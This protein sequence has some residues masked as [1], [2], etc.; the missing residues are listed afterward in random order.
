VAGLPNGLFELPRFE[1]PGALWESVD[2]H[3]PQK[4]IST[5]ADWGQRLHLNVA[6]I[7]RP[8]NRFDGPGDFQLM[9]REQI[10]AIHGFNEDMVLGWHVD[11]NLCRRLYLLNGNTESLLDHVFAYHCDHTRQV[12]AMHDSAQRTENDSK[13]FIYDVNSPYLLNQAET[14]GL[15]HEDIEET[16]LTS[17]T[18][19]TYGQA[20]EKLLPG[21]AEPVAWDSYLDES[22]DQSQIYDNSHV[23]P[24]LADY[25]I[26]I[27]RSSTIGYFGGNVELLDLL[28]KFLSKIGH[29][30][31]V[32]VDSDLMACAFPDRSP[33][34][35]ENFRLEVAERL[36]AQSD[37]YVF[38]IAL[39]HLQ[40]PSNAKDLASLITCQQA[41][42]FKEKLANFF[43][44]TVAY[45]RNRLLSKTNLERQFL[46]IGAHATWFERI[47]LK[48]M[49]TTV[50]PYSSHVRQGFASKTPQS[51]VS[52]WSFA[53]RFRRQPFVDKSGLAR[54]FSREGKR[55]LRFRDYRK[56]QQYFYKALCLQPL[57]GKN[58]RRLLLAY[59]W[60]LRRLYTRYKTR[61]QTSYAK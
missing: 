5:F 38:D 24:Y 36:L 2:R 50:T 3:D 31:T 19:S 60:G 40:S 22:Y 54:H 46:L 18:C 7:A 16:R 21:M 4:I 53:R 10:F 49:G 11:S 59:L 15:K 32:L 30:G 29:R 35:P 39:M 12:T 61:R 8:E 27:D 17:E 37:V 47:V 57:Y 51:S 33:R 28:H 13:R 9:L 56:A 52:R 44:R 48:A 6:V 42:D 45:E 23:F 20:L 58:L 41:E 43:Y 26:D 1:V 34:L 25:L 55:S 14:W